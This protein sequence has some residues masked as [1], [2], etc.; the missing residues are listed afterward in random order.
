MT[1]QTSDCEN[2]VLYFSEKVRKIAACAMREVHVSR[3]MIFYATSNGS[4]QPTHTCNLISLLN[5]L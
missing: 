3:D 5:I 4:D 1:C 2:L